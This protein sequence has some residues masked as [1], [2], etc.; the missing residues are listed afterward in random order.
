MGRGEDA[1]DTTGETDHHGGNDR[2]H[3]KDLGG[4]RPRDRHHA[5]QELSGAGR[6]A[7]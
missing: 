7:A 6:E 3:V 4:S 2:A 1:A 5:G